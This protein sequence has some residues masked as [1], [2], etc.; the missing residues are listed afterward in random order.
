MTVQ[1]GPYRIP[2]PRFSQTI[3]RNFVLLTLLG[4]LLT[5]VLGPAAGQRPEKQNTL[6]AQVLPAGALLTTPIGGLERTRAAVQVVPV[7][8]QPFPKAL[9]VI[10]RAGSPETNATQLTIPIIVPIERGDALLASFS[11]RG[12][13]ADGKEPA[14]AEFLFEGSTDP[15]TKS[16]SQDAVSPQDPRLWKRV[17]VPFTAAEAY[18]PGEA[19]VSLRLAFGPQTV[20]IG[21]LSVVNYARTRTTE[22]L[23]ALAASDNPLGRA[24]VRVGLTD[25]KQTLLGL[26]GDFC[27]PRY[28]ATTAMDAVGAFNL[29]HLRV[30]H[31]RVGIPLN[32]WAPQ[33]DVYR[34]EAQAHAALL[35]MQQLSRRKIPLC[36]SVWEGPA[37]L[38]GGQA[39]Q[40]GRTLAPEKYADCIEA[41]A[42]FLVTARDK[43]G[44]TVDDFSFNEPDY[45]VNFKFTSTQM[46]AFIRQ[47][48]PR[49][50]ALGL[51][52]NF[53]I[54]DTAGG[55]QFAGYARPLL[56]DR[57]LAPYLG[58]LAFH[59]WDVL[60]APPA[61]YAQ[62]AALGRQ[63]HKTIWCTEAGH[64]S[65][66]WQALDPW[67][68]WENGLRTALA[69]EKT[70]RLTGASLMDYWTYQDNYPIVS[71]DGTHPF[72]VFSV[73]RQMEDAL[74]SG[75][76]VVSAASDHEDLRALATAG[77]QPGQFSVLL[78]NPV[79]AG[80]VT[81]SGLPPGAFVSAVGSD[82]AAQRKP[83]VTHARVD[84]SGSL[85]LTLTSRS[86]VTVLSERGNRHSKFEGSTKR[87]NPH[88]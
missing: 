72:P 49:F 60:G 43:Y 9:R 4:F 5:D 33:K 46:A 82:A 52:T 53:L 20:E 16:A 63:Y 58:P 76:R 86:V 61:G 66:L 78:V 79:G 87:I 6:P 12:I 51:K 17:L 25:R 47:A 19:M 57:S 24:R 27:Q 73:L 35:L 41:V 83:L 42:Q 28:G 36:G 37:W 10:I 45:G 67:Q 56:A 23:I 30:A 71:R 29:E 14:Q 65:G 11:L 32:W 21:G 70:L 64:D 13:S 15:W 22:E 2:K 68:H 69:Y 81:L 18:K 34:D 44:V 77:P 85:V 1:P 38:L 8:G 48:G 75:A 50:R 80:Q 54:G 39:E 26:G 7:T 62:I 55:A 59:C 40:S 74:P 3:S 84:R 31:A 88:A